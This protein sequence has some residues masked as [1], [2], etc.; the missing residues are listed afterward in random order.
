MPI[1]RVCWFVGWF[2][3]MR[4]P[5]ALAGSRGRRAGVDQHRI[6]F[7]GTLRSLAPM[8]VFF[9]QRVSIASYVSAGIARAE[10]SVCPS[11]C[12]SVRHTPVLYQNEES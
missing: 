10:M 3:T 9:Y 12:L 6:G 11:V 2:V 7:A 1:R 4:S 8:S 5:T